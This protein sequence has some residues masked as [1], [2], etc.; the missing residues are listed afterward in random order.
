MNRV[1]F[2]LRI[3]EKE[4]GLLKH[5]SEIEDRSINDLLNE[6][7]KAFLSKPTKREARLE[8]TLAGLRA[9]RQRD[10]EFQTAIAAFVEAEAVFEDPLEAKTGPVQAKLRDLFNA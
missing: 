4:H 8:A 2:T 9:Y 3:D 6:V 10:P 1:P 7:I 5:L